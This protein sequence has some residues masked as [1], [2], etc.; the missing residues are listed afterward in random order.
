M[1]LLACLPHGWN[2]GIFSTSCALT[3]NRTHT[4]SF[5][6]TEGTLIE[7]ALLTELSR[8]WQRLAYMKFPSLSIPLKVLFVS[9]SF[10]NLQAYSHSKDFFQPLYDAGGNQTHIN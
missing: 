2:S 4:T 10:P 7:D 5:A 3:G 9:S 1:K 8:P 6:P